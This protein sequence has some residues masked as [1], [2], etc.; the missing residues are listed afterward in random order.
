MDQ[1]TGRLSERHRRLCTLVNCITGRVDVT[2]RKIIDFSS[3]NALEVPDKVFA[4]KLG[5]AEQV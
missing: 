4:A 1:T 3:P 2:S 5:E